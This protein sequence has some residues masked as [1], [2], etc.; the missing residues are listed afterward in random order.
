MAFY[1]LVGEEGNW[2]NIGSLGVIK[3]D[4]DCVE[5]QKEIQGYDFT[6]TREIEVRSE[7]SAEDYEE[8]CYTYGTKVVR[9]SSEGKNETIPIEDVKEGEYILAKGT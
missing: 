3:F 5:E 9:R 4:K 1:G 8:A 2:G 7:N 6:W